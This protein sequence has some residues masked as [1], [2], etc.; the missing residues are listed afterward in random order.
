MLRA[1]I[2]SGQPN[3]LKNATEFLTDLMVPEPDDGDAFAGQKVFSYLIALFPDRITMAGT[4][5]FDGEFQSR[6]IEIQD[7]RI[8]WMLSPEFVTCEISISQMTPENTLAICCIFAEMTGTTHGG[9]ARR[10]SVS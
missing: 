8:D 1:V 3:R 2:L 10:I 4:I 5:Q 7:V 6:T 9:I